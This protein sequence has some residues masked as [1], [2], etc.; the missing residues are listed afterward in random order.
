V[1]STRAMG[2]ALASSAAILSAPATAQ[3]APAASDVTI[4]RD[5]FGVP[6][7]YGESAAAI[8][9]GAAYAMAQD[10]LAQGEMFMRSALGRMAEIMGKD[11]VAA[12]KD[13]RRRTLTEA[14]LKAQFAALS[15]EHQA[16][17]TAMHAGW[18]AYVRQVRADPK[19]LPY[20]FKEWG[21]QPTEWTLWQFLDVMGSL[22][23]GYGSGGGGHELVNLAF[24][25]EM[26]AKHGEAKAKRIFDDVLPLNDPDAVPIIPD[27]DL[28]RA[29]APAAAFGVQAAL[30]GVGAEALRRLADA[31][32]AARAFTQAPR[33]ASRIFM[34][35]ANK[36]A[37]GKPIML[38]ATAD[39][40][41]IHITG[42]GFNVA[43]FILPP[44][45]PVIM[46]RTPTNGFTFTTGESDLV[47]IYAEKINPANPRQYWHNGAWRDMA[48][49]E[50]SIAVKGGAPVAFTVERTVHGPVIEREDAARVAYTEKNS[51]SGYELAGLAAMIELNRAHDLASYRRAAEMMPFNFNVNYAGVDG[52]I[53]LYHSGRLPI[54][55]KNVDPRLPVPGTGEYEWSGVLDPKQH[56]YVVDPAQGYLHAWNNKVTS[57][58]YHG[59]TSRYGRSWR[60]WIGRKL[61]ESKAK[62]TM[63]DVREFHRQMGSSGGAADLTVTSPTFFTPYLKTIAA[64]DAKLTAMVAAMDSWNG[65][66][67]DLNGDKV[68]DNPGLTIYRQWIDTAQKAVV[69]AEIGEWW[70][71]ID[72]DNYIKYRTDVLLRVIEGKDA[73]APVTHDWFSG[74]NRD[75][76]L[77][78]TLTDTAAALTQ[79]FGSDEISRWRQPIY[80]RFYDKAAQAKNPDK[81]VFGRDL[82]GSTAGKLGLQP[83]YVPANLSESWNMLIKLTP[84]D[85]TL[86]DSTPTGG[87]NMFISADGKGNPNIADQVMLH[88]NYQ[89]KPV[90]LDR[91][92]VEKAAVS[93]QRLRMESGAR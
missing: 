81:P 73:G 9:Y 36:S 28:R 14:E 39:G 26:V 76:V 91:A 25:R 16:I 5:K 77:R 23:R 27:A 88:V 64:G 61:A 33:G 71:K 63:D 74:R 12:D 6:H 72:D 45:C 53:A 30:P 2:W 84:E 44:I 35:G 41:D 31:R 22:Q 86:Y 75:A 50:E 3:T 37:D 65:V 18:H 58:S 60:T 21:I 51:I 7:V 62:V 40:P 17:L 29:Q 66:F 70:H 59:D 10:R 54:R 38:H 83:A 79:R 78:K 55:P 34:I 92:A 52:H 1:K 4:H 89:F 80:Y 32:E 8:Y 68:Y 87:Q 11:L 43:G 90:A 13:A 24:H 15:P 47:D 82:P 49:R 48:T 42:A 57:A 69:G 46:G 19:K 56:P 85:T 20:E 93:T 67:E